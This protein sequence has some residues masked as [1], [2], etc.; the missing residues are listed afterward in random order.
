M[1]D[2]QRIINKYTGMSQLSLKQE[3]LDTFRDIM[4]DNAIA[5]AEADA[6]INYEMINGFRDAYEDQSKIDLINSS[7][8]LYDVAGKYYEPAV[9]GGIDAY[10]VFLAHMNGADGSQTFIDDSN[11]AHVI[12][13][14][15]N[16]QIDTAYYK[17]PT[18]SGLFDGIGDYGSMPVSDDF[19]LG[20][21]NF[22]GEFW[23]RRSGNIPD[24]GGVFSTSDGTTNGWAI[25]FGNG[26]TQNYCKFAAATGGWGD[27]LVSDT[28][29]PDNTLTH[30]AIVRS[31]NTLK[32]YQAGLEVASADVTG[33][34][35]ADGTNNPNIGRLFVTTDNYYL[36]AHLDE[37]RISKG[38]D[39]GWTGS[40]ITV[41]TFPY[42]ASKHNMTLISKGFSVPAVPSAARMLHKIQ[43]LT[44]VELDTDLKFYLSRNGD[45]NRIKGT[46]ELLRTIG[47]NKLIGVDFNL[48]G[49]P[50]GTDMVYRT[51]SDNNKN[52]YSKALA[53]Q[54]K[55]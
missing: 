45:T 51:V 28:I 31:G 35:F 33:L 4:M 6:A 10:T 34:D 23:I 18:G 30:F 29:L 15:G 37:I 11:S 44:S 5:V 24:Y 53:C 22:V 32:M 20:I 17:F 27:K 48:S 3:V 36:K 16:L 7:N 41:P 49:L 54:I 38:I 19:D 39:R 12:T 42:S 13:A 2:F 14:H 50:S 43:Y 21:G 8:I 26:A 47:L 52:F 55:T 25:Y 46:P 40:T 9:S 1:S